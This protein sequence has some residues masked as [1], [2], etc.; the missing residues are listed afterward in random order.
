MLVRLRIN[1]TLCWRGGGFWAIWRFGAGAVAGGL[2][3]L[4]R[5]ALAEQLAKQQKRVIVFN[6]PGGLSQ[7]ESWDPKRAGTETGG[8]F[9][10]ISHFGARFTYQRAVAGYS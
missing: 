7:L 6:M 10:A 2:G 9:R 8:P 3:W 5:P 4:A 1:G